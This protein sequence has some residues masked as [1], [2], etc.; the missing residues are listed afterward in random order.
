MSVRFE[1]VDFCDLWQEK[2]VKYVVM[3][4][5]WRK[6][7]VL[8]YLTGIVVAQGVTTAREHVPLV[9][10]RFG[11]DL[12]MI[13][14]GPSLRSTSTVARPRVGT[15]QALCLHGLDGLKAPKLSMGLVGINV[16]VV[17]SGGN[18]HEQIS[19]MTSRTPQSEICLL[20]CCSVKAINTVDHLCHPVF[21]P[22]AVAFSFKFCRRA[23]VWMALVT[24]A[25]E[26][27]QL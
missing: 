14:L 19:T 1:E 11:E 23:R 10:S 12:T 13:S 21:S 20:L 16:E 26:H 15:R 2:S 24:S 27:E 5:R 18:I 25:S 17:R 22:T 3:S 9:C 4:E 8:Y 7:L 6:R